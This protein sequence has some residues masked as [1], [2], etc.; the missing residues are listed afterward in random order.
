M[1]YDFDNCMLTL[2]DMT[3][4][5]RDI[6]K[7]WV[8]DNIDMILLNAQAIQRRYTTGKL[9]VDIAVVCDGFL[10]G[11]YQISNDEFLVQSVGYENAIKQDREEETADYLTEENG[12]TPEAPEQER[13]VDNVDDQTED[14]G[15]VPDFL[16]CSYDL[17]INKRHIRATKELLRELSDAIEIPLADVNLTLATPELF[18]EAELERLYYRRFFFKT[19]LSAVRDVKLHLWACSPDTYFDQRIILE[20]PDDELPF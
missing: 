13:E 7:S 5:N 11:I 16:D 2:D 3:Q 15:S 8:D 6:I 18:D 9:D 19:V 20:S 10:V 1:K 4:C 12:N 14:N 17:T